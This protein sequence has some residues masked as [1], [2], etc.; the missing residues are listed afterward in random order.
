M[1]QRGNPTA[2]TSKGW[3]RDTSAGVTWLAEV[4]RSSLHVQTYSIFLSAKSPRDM[5]T[6]RGA[7]RLVSVDNTPED[8][9]STESA[10]EVQ[11]FAHA[12]NNT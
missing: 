9:R 2:T 3:I 7:P 11:F 1:F 12:R 5:N 8:P 6:S 10:E 4:Q